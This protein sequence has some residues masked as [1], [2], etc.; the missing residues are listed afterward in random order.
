MMEFTLLTKDDIHIVKDFLDPTVYEGFFEGD[1]RYA[2]AA[3]KDK[4][5]KGIG[6]FDAKKIIEIVD[7]AVVKDCP[8][9]LEMRILREMIQIISGLDYKGIIMNIYDLDHRK[10]IAT[11]LYDEGFVVAEK[12]VLYRFLLEDLTAA[13]LLQK[14]TDRKGICFL[15]EV[16][17]KAKKVFS[18]MLIQKGLFEHFL[19]E[20]ISE[21]L[22]TVYMRD[23]RISGCVLINSLDEY[24]F[25]VEYV[26]AD[27]GV[28]SRVLPALLA[29][30]T[31][32][33]YEY[34]GGTEADGFILSTSDRT[35]K[36]ILK[37]LPDADRVD[38]CKTFAC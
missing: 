35:E 4:T 6:V 3:S 18:N 10:T 30:G 15:S 11:A 16:D 5:V 33:L 31:D 1:C 24:T 17:E 19:S 7:I 37:V 14:A 2:I 22:S 29:A 20:D 32:A 9:K 38:C 21:R 12:K 28:S 27:E 36:M 13:P 8:P 25:Y 23:G 34:Y 26:Y